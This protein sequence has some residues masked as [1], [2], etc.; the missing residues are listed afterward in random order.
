MDRLIEL[1]A[2]AFDLIFKKEQTLK[3]CDE[4]LNAVYKEMDSIN[5]ALQKAPVP[6]EALED[7]VD[8]LKVVGVEDAGDAENT[9]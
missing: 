9:S 7:M 6:V 1:K 4:R 3:A 2:E 8:G 5:R